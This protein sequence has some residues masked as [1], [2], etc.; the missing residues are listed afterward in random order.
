MKKLNQHSLGTLS[1][2]A[3]SLVAMANAQSSTPQIWFGPLTWNL[4]EP[5]PGI[6]YTRHDFAMFL[7]SD[8]PWQDAASQVAVLELPGNVVWSYP[9]LP[10][11]VAF[12]KRHQFK[13]GFGDGM[14][15]TGG[16]CGKGIEGISQDQDA[17]RET[18]IIAEKWKQ[19]GGTLDYIDMDS[20]YYFGTYYAKDCHFSIR[21]VAE[22]AGATLKG[23]LEYFPDVHVAD[24]EGPG[25]I[26]DE[27]WLPGMAEW[28][29]EFQKVT[30][31]PIEA[32]P[33]D[34]HWHDL[35]PGYTWQQTTRRAV[36]YFRQFNVRTGLIVDAESD[37][38]TTDLQWMNDVRAHI[39][40]ANAAKLDLDF[41]GIYSWM[42]HPT[43]NL[44]ETD[45]LGYT[46]LINY[47]VQTWK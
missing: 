47:T 27:Q 32:V 9:D 10:S 19:A 46:S 15:F 45:P 3:F 35:R 36:N 5:G 1:L 41:V 31:R 43:R 37:P 28:F 20:P 40:E 39:R 21:D 2:V 44:P 38:S 8:A 24:A 17:N 26:P 33:L 18:I 29:K 22:R 30:G 4:K 23:V 12:T 14:L 7:K 13:I 11:L 16:K 42:N 25:Q 6:E 34:L